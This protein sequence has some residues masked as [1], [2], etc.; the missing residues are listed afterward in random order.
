MTV[1]YDN[2]D[3][4]NGFYYNKARIGTITIH[5]H[6]FQPEDVVITATAANGGEP[7]ELPA[8]SGW[9]SSGDVHT[10]SVAYTYDGEFTF[11]VS[12]TDLAGNEAE[13]YAGDHFV[14]DLTEP[15]LEITGIEDQSANNDRVAPAITWSDLNLDTD[16][17]LLELTGVNRGAAEVETAVA[18]IEGG[19][20]IQ[21]RD[22]PRIQEMD[23]LYTLHAAVTDLAGNT[24]EQTITFSVNRFGSVYIFDDATEQLLEQYYVNEPV[25]LRV[26]EINVDTLEFRE[27]TYSR[28]GDIVTMEPGEDYDVTESGTEATWKSYTYDIYEENFTEEG[29]YSVTIYSEDRAANRSNNA[30]KEK[31]IH[32]VMDTTPPT[33]VVSGVENQGQYNSDRQIVTIDAK[34]N[35]ALA[36]VTAYLNQTPVKTFTAEELAENNGVVTLEIGSSSDWQTL[37]VEAADAA[38][39]E[40]RSDTRVFLIT[41]NVLIR[42]YRNTPLFWGSLAAAAVCAGFIIVIVGKKKKRK[43]QETA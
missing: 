20:T 43:E 3:A 34:D 6:N 7:I 23:D 15:V 22:F 12:Y 31:E 26:T 11:D 33:V 10:A 21:Y 40:G 18:A 4:R 27:I 13:D 24:S 19:M 1:T 29:I 35:I 2:N 14:V 28:D 25:R 36:Q 16:G 17:I 39:N 37:A 9:S 5:E 8:V 32:F 30:A 41:R 38:G 42:W